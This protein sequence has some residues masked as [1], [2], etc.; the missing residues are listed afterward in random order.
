MIA[1]RLTSQVDVVADTLPP[2]MSQPVEQLTQPEKQAAPA[3][4]A[5]FYRPELDALRFFAFVTVFCFHRADFLPLDHVHHPIA[6][7]IAWIGAFGVTLFFLLSAF[8]IVELLL[9]EKEKVGDIHIGSFYVRRVLRIWPLYF[10]A[11][12][13]L[14]LLGHWIPAV[15]MKTPGSILA[16]TFF[17]GNW[18]VV[19]Y[20][21]IAG[22][23]DPLWSISVEE[24]FYFCIPVLMRW[25]GKKALAW[26]SV[27]FLVLS[28]VTIV[29][30]ARKDGP[31]DNGQ[32]T[33]SWFQFQFFAA[34]ALL[35]LALHGKLPQF[36][37]PL[38]LVLFTLGSGSWVYAFL[39]FGA[40]SWEPHV[41][42][43]AA[44]LG[45]GLVLLGAI[46]FFLSVYGIHERYIPRWLSYLGR[47]S[48]GL[49]I[50][51]SLILYLLLGLGHQWLTRLIA[52]LHLPA[53]SFAPVGSA[54][55]MAI[56]ISLAALSYR[57][58][59]QPFLRLKSR[60]TIVRSRPEG[61]AS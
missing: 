54:L 23:I 39:G 19:R 3:A 46:F 41:H 37:A 25:G 6:Y 58:Y 40:K 13:G 34:G 21:W 31:G 24:Q 53:S 48:Y 12:Y 8:L 17:A 43:L 33:N 20:G 29:L 56:T 7:V 57:F 51:H 36:T 26:I 50:F 9:R 22:P 1:S 27:L 16:F 11:L 32:W 30:Y 5:R 44:V 38:R 45:W 52:T 28:Y 2:A 49:Y 4:R 42:P 14:T 60:F 55:V 47:V 15:G 35:A 18:Y 10:A 61:G 59:E